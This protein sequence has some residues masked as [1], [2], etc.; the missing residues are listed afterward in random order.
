MDLDS[1]LDTCESI[2]LR[3]RHPV[4]DAGGF[5]LPQTTFEPTPSPHINPWT[6]F[7]AAPSDCITPWTVPPDLSNRSLPPMPGERYRSFDASDVT[8]TLP[9]EYELLLES[10]AHVVGIT[11]TEMAEVVESFERRLEKHRTRNGDR[12]RSQSRGRTTPAGLRK[13]ASFG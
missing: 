9:R 13:R 1:Y 11:Q 2:L 4:A 8:G 3:D 6:P 10:A 5:P 7:H 12:S